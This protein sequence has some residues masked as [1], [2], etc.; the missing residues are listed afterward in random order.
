[1]SKHTDVP[2]TAATPAPTNASEWLAVATVDAAVLDLR[3]DYRALL[4]SADGLHGGQSNLVSERVLTEANRP[5]IAPMRISGAA[6]PRALARE[7]MVPVRM[8]G[9]AYG[10]TWSRVTSHLEAPTP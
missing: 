5:V 10:K 9:A 1:M 4:L 7:S 8:P 2:S 3:P 6:S